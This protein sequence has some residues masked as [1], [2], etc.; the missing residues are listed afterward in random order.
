MRK[1]RI[2]EIKLPNISWMVKT[3]GLLHCVL[4]PT[5]TSQDSSGIINFNPHLPFLISVFPLVPFL[6][7]KYLLISSLLLKIYFKKKNAFQPC[8]I[9]RLF[10]MSLLSFA[11]NYPE[12]K[13]SPHSIPLLLCLIHSAQFLLKSGFCFNIHKPCLLNPHWAWPPSSISVL[14]TNPTPFF[15]LYPGIALSW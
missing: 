9:F 14:L 13:R 8:L 12:K 4:D 1:L 10:S 2:R 5:P 15:K 11:I 3:R 6:L 7:S